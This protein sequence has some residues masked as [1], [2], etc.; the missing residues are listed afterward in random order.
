MG[1]A[2]HPHVRALQQHTH[3][4]PF[5]DEEKPGLGRTG[6]MPRS[7]QAHTSLGLSGPGAQRARPAAV[8]PRLGAGALIRPLPS[9]VRAGLLSLPYSTPGGEAGE[10]GWPL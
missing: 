10:G 9:Q 6:L 1:R 4:A 3:P 2:A 8:P 7:Q 5:Q